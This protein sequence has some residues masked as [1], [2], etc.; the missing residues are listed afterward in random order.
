MWQH[1]ATTIIWWSI[2][3]GYYLKN[4]RSP[5]RFNENIWLIY[6][7]VFRRLQLGRL[8]LFWPA[9]FLL[10]ALLPSKTSQFFSQPSEILKQFDNLNQLPGARAWPSLESAPEWSDAPPSK[11]FSNHHVIIIIFIITI[12]V[13]DIWV[14]VIFT[15]RRRKNHYQKQQKCHNSNKMFDVATNPHHAMMQDRQERGKNS[16]GPRELEAWLASVSASTSFSAYSS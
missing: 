11:Q 15:I 10:S 8:I 7:F 4:P 13:I 2:P 14:W 3:F 9:R 12:I 5:Y 16:G 1:K 6:R